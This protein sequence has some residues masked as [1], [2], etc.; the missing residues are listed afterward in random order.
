M[1]KGIALR[2]LVLNRYGAEKDCF[3]KAKFSIVKRWHRQAAN[4]AAMALQCSGRQCGEMN[5]DD[6]ARLRLAKPKH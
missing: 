6:I 3:A 2:C 1:S 4:C 5:C